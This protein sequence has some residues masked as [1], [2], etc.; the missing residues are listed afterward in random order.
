MY[1]QNQNKTESLIYNN[2]DI[3]DLSC[4]CNRFNTYF[5]STGPNLVQSINPCGQ[6]DLKHYCPPAKTVRFVI[7]PL[8]KLSKNI[9]FS[10]HE[11]KFRFAICHRPSISLL[12]VVCNVRA[13]YSDNWNFLQYFYAVWYNGHLWPFGKNFT[14]IVPGEPLCR[15]S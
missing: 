1:E 10:E 7:L 13:P 6:S 5:S 8:M 2:E 3:T 4:I 15:G 12:S 9:T 14:E 11:L